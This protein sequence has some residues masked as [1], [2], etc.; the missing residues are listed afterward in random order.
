VVSFAV[1]GNVNAD[2][3]AWPA[4]DVPSPGTERR[5]ERIDVRVGGGSAITGAA[6]A[7]LGGSP[8][9]VG[10]VGRDALGRV[11]LEELRGYGVDTRHV[12]EIAG[13]PTGTSIAFEAPGRDRSFLIALGS[14]A[15]FDAS[16]IPDEVFAASHVLLCGYFNL[17]AMRGRP[18]HEALAQIRARGGMTLLD[19]GWDH[20][21]WSAR[22]RDE[23]TRLLPFVD[24]FVPNEAEAERLSGEADPVEAG[25]AISR[26]SG[27]WTVVKLGA[28]GAV[29]VSHAGRSRRVSAPTVDVVDTTGAGDAFNAGL[30]MALGSGL[31]PADALEH[32]VRVGSTV[33][34][35][36][37][38][39]R[40]PT[41]EEVLRSPAR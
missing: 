10:C 36:R 26:R 34:S 37:S 15:A 14:L 1:V 19:T 8:A 9:V 27:A 32:A 16:M 22:T 5:I 6:L 33:V 30:M 7:R 29:S 17:P 12:R 31:D 18:T 4:S 40:Y 25:A 35:R 21:G 20:D 38:D 39:D 24:V 13:A 3:V 23:I 11:A 2:L 28:L 41:A